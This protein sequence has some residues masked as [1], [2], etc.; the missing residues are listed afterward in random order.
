MS[1]T[2]AS[3]EVDGPGA[4]GMAKTLLD[5]AG[6]KTG[7]I[8]N[9]DIEFTFCDD[10][11]TTLSIDVDGPL[12]GE[13]L[14]VLLGGV[15][16]EDYDVG[17]VSANVAQRDESDAEYTDADFED[18][19]DEDTETDGG[20]ST[21]YKPH[22]S[23]FVDSVDPDNVEF[24]QIHPGRIRG[25]TVQHTTG[26]LILEARTVLSEDWMS[27]D[28]LADFAGDELSLRAAQTNLSRLFTDKGL[29]VR[30]RKANSGTRA[31]E[32]HPTK[33]LAEEIERLGPHD[34]EN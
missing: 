31:Y 16:W 33:Q 28:I 14:R 10:T 24:P 30:R 12:S 34:G 6:I 5:S 18:D 1:P 25:D 4:N 3:I 22:V 15:E 21:A 19:D 17:R 29:L 32:Y 9:S 26:S 2:N 8:Q 23:T 7:G 20:A 13:V 11:D 27:G